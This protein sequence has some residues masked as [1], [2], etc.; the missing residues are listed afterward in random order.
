MKSFLILLLLV[1]VAIA[2][3][4]IAG[5]PAPIKQDHSKLG[6]WDPHTES[7]HID[8]SHVTKE[9][10]EMLRNAL[11]PSDTQK[12]DEGISSGQKS[13]P[14]AKEVSPRLAQGSHW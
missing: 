13:P 2:V 4:P 11:H 7:S 6:E 3:T 1:I 5:A 10:W 14:K 9:D 12:Q 8:D